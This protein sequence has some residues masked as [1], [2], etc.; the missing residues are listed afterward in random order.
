L[1]TTQK[2]GQNVQVWGALRGFFAQSLEGER[3]HQSSQ[4]NKGGFNRGGFFLQENKPVFIEGKNCG[5]RPKDFQH[6]PTAERKKKRELWSR[7]FNFGVKTSP[8][9][10]KIP[11]EK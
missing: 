5:Q 1:F 8:R 11:L 3:K 7:T 9:N 4:K 10:Q 2:K 6:C